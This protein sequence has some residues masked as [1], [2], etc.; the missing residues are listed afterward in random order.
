VEN[1]GDKMRISNKMIFII[2]KKYR[3]AIGD[4]PGTVPKRNHITLRCDLNRDCPRG[5]PHFVRDS[6]L[7]DVVPY[8]NGITI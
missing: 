6:K 7:R 1:D 4:S 3:W 8:E 5:C 2:M